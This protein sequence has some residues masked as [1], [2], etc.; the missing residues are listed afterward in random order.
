MTDKFELGTYL[1]GRVGAS[2]SDLTFAPI[3]GQREYFYDSNGN[4]DPATLTPLHL[5]V[6]KFLTPHDT[7]RIYPSQ[8]HYFGGGVA[9]GLAAEVMEYSIW[10]SNTWLNNAADWTMISNPISYTFPTVGNPVYGFAGVT[11]A[12]EIWRGGSTEGSLDSPS[13]AIQNGLRSGLHDGNTLS[14]LWVS[15]KLD[16]DGRGHG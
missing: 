6:Y 1:P 11:E 10:G 3:S 9:P 4:N 14:V 5:V 8:D 7:V 12:A 2:S 16:C 15:G 13:R